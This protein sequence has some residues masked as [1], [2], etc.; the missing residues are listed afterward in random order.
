MYRYFY[1]HSDARED[2]SD[3][4]SEQMSNTNDRT[5]DGKKSA[6][7]FWKILNLFFFVF[8][9]FRRFEYLL[10][11]VHVFPNPSSHSHNLCMLSFPIFMQFFA[12][13]VILFIMIIMAA[14]HQKPLMCSKDTPCT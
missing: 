4:A 13:V 7:T 12:A 11:F 3:T 1:F 5:K 8:L 14:K 9:C 10:L 6:C 2:V